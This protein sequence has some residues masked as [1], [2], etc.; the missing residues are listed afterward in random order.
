LPFEVQKMIYFVFIHSQLAY[1]IEIYGITS[2]C[3]YI[4]ASVDG[5]LPFWCAGFANKVI[6]FSL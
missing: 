3:C 5:R 1:G 6:S 4:G 2:M